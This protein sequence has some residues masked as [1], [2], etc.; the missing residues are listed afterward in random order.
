MYQPFLPLRFTSPLLLSPSP[1]SYLP[2]L[3]III[4]SSPST[5]TSPSPSPSHSIPHSPIIASQFLEI[6]FDIV[7]SDGL[8]A[9]RE[10]LEEG[11][12]FGFEVV[13]E[14]YAFCLFFGFLLM[15]LGGK[16]GGG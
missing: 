10:G 14:D 4:I 15:G 8:A 3:I 1:G 16:G 13:V 12:Y 6:G 11:F 2:S 7:C 5:S 9:L